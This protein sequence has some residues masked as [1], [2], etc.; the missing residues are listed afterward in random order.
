[1]D[2]LHV[3]MGLKGD[4]RIFLNEIQEDLNDPRA[5]LDL[6]TGWESYLQTE[7]ATIANK[8]ITKASS[9]WQRNATLTHEEECKLDNEVSALN[10]FIH[11]QP[12]SID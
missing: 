1:M 10:C 9:R 4:A 11:S 6:R 8:P 3:K 5:M 12:I 2:K 7:M